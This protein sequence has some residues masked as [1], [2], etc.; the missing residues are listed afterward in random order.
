M[1]PEQVKGETSDPR[2]DVFAL[3]VVPFEAVT[4]RRAFGG[5]AVPEV[6][7]AI[8]RD[9]PPP[10]ESVQHGVP[11]SLESV[12][13]RCLAKRPA[14]SFS[15]GRAVEAALETVLASLEPRRV[16]GARPLEPRGPW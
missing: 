1:S 6:L 14:D 2:T 16:S 7:A 9:E 11:A 4:G 5:S 3:G 10:L 13:R 8:L 15:S 12:V